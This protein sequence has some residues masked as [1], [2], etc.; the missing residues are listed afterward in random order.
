MKRKQRLLF[1]TWTLLATAVPAQRMWTADQCMQYAVD[2]SRN[3]R[4]GRL[5]LADYEAERMR[6]AGGFLPSVG[7]SV[8]GQVNFGRAID[9]ETNTYTTVSTLYNSYGLSASIPVFDGLQRYNELH[10]ARASV[11]MGRQGVLA[12]K[13]QVAQ[14]VLKQYVDAV[15]QMGAL[16]LARQKREESMALL[17]QSRAMA[18][19]GLRSEADTAQMRATY[20]SDDCEV[21]RQE[22]LLS[23]ALL[24]LK[25]TMNYPVDEPLQIDTA[26]VP[27]YPLVACQAGEL[28]AQAC[29]WNPS[30]L[31]AGYNLK[32]ARLGL[33]SARGAFFPSLSVGAGI[34][35]S[36]YRQVGARGTT[37]FGG[38][39][40]NNRGEH[41]YATLSIPVFNRLG[42]LANLRRQ[43]NNVA[44]AQETLGQRQDDLRVLI[45]QTTSDQRN[46]CKELQKTAARVEADS[47]ASRLT[48]QKYE[49]GL[50]SAI[51]VQTA[52]VTL[53]QSR[54]QLLQ[55]R[56]QNYY[57]TRIL[58]YYKGMPLWT[59]E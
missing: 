7:A 56:L 8:G 47:V 18:E 2:H 51:E 31:M 14:Q 34:S 59:E 44:R 54:A 24:A 6:A 36:Y 48:R 5:T 57:L 32:V 29:G 45:E 23:N 50:A 38:Q 39:F 58:N 15:Y 28:Y 12:Q 40:R 10:A 13:E 43:R 26:A 22:C 52:A 35:T 46:S 53:L 17:V 11:L 30:V 55:S 16:R 21:T 9:P 33:R 20:A 3:V 1:I 37:G 42:L 19:V 27:T 41:V 49:E 25:T 4:A